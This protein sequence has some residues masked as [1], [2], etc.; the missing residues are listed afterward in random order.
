MAELLGF[1]KAGNEPELPSKY[2]QVL[3]GAASNVCTVTCVAC[4]RRRSS[5]AGA[6]VGERA[7]KASAFETAV[8]AGILLTAR[9]DTKDTRLA[10][11]NE[12]L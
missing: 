2:P 1:R 3:S 5:V 9:A 6:S 7:N 10:N 4:L 12:H 8:A 11:A